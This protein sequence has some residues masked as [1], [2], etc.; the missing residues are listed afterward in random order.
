MSTTNTTDRA[1]LLVTLPGELHERLK[2]IAAVNQRSDTGLAEELITAFIEEREWV[3]AIEVGLRDVEQGRTV[4]F[5]DV[6]TKWK[7]KLARSSAT[8]AGK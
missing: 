1:H 8:R 2:R 6:K 4:D 7:R 5:D 3:A